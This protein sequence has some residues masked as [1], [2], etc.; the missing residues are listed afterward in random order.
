MTQRTLFYLWKKSP[1][2]DLFFLENINYC[3]ACINLAT[4][5]DEIKVKTHAR[6]KQLKHEKNMFYLSHL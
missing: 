2:I 5:P 1:A 6:L 4:F 3:T